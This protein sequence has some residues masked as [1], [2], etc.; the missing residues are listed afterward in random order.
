MADKD[1]VSES[2]GDHGQL[3]GLTVK[4]YRDTYLLAGWTS[5][6]LHAPAQPMRVLELQGSYPPS[7]EERSWRGALSHLVGGSHLGEALI[8]A[9]PHLG[10]L[11]LG[12]PPTSGPL[13][14]APSHLAPPWL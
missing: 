7:R 1:D 6:W 13:T 2:G 11:L 14:W 10:S 4:G 12:S 3:V 8:W 5:P 9:S